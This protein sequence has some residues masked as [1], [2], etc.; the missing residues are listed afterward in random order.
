MSED[1]AAWH[2]SARPPVGP[3][4]EILEKLTERIRS[5]SEGIERQVSELRARQRGLVGEADEFIQERRMLQAY[6]KYG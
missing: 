5:L 6:V 4:R 1:I 3:L 2:A